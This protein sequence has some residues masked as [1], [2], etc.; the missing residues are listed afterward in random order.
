MTII[1][2]DV[3]MLELRQVTSK[4]KHWEEQVG[5]G[6]WE[7]QS[8]DVI[9]MTCRGGLGTFFY[10]FEFLLTTFFQFH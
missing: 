10:Y 4:W 7:L 2:F 3:E 5:T 1:L 8:G 9:I 6:A